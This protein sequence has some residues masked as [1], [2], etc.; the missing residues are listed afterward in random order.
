MRDRRSDQACEELLA[1]GVSALRHDF[2]IVSLGAFGPAISGEI[3]AVP[4]GR[5][6]ATIAF[7]MPNT[8]TLSSGKPNIMLF[9]PA[10]SRGCV[11]VAAG[12]LDHT[13]LGAQGFDEVLDVK[14][15]RRAALHRDSNRVGSVIFKSSILG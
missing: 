3:R 13:H 10:G 5:P 6:S 11:A 12:R 4:R 8:I 2:A 1:G 14:R 9:L 15:Q 7:P